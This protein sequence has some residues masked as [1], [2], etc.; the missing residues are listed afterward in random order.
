MPNKCKAILLKA[1]KQSFWDIFQSIA[2]AAFGVQSQA[3]RERDFQQ[4]SI[5]P[6]IVGG[7]IFVALFVAILLSV[8]AFIL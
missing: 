7:I 4:T 1:T 8:V 2:A 5:A 6:F 3:N